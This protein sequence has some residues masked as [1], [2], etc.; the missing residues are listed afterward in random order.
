M[1]KVGIVAVKESVLMERTYSK[2]ASY[3]SLN[4]ISLPQLS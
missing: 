1:F 3:P 4:V 2:H